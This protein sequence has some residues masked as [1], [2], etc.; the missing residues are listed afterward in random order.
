MLLTAVCNDID[1]CGLALQHARLNCSHC[2]HRRVCPVTAMHPHSVWWSNFTARRCKVGGTRGS[3]S[4]LPGWHPPPTHH[5]KVQPGSS[6]IVNKR[7]TKVKPR[8]SAN[9]RGGLPLFPE[10][11][12]RV[13]LGNRASAKSH[14]RKPGFRHGVFSETLIHPPKCLCV[15]T[16]AKRGLED[17]PL[18]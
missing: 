7:L 5:L 16:R 17:E 15:R 12:R 10:N 18:S 1:P 4:L 2:L 6:F 3:T 8:S 9:L 11:P 13:L 14:S